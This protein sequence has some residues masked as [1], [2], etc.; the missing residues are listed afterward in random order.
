MFIERQKLQLTE[1]DEELRK[2]ARANRGDPSDEMTKLRLRRTLERSKPL[3]NLDKKRIL[4]NLDR[5][6]AR[7]ERLRSSG[8][9][10]RSKGLELYRILNRRDL[11]GAAQYR[12][13][14]DPDNPF[15]RS[16]LRR[17]ERI[18]DLAKLARKIRKQ[19]PEDPRLDR[20]SRLRTITQLRNDLGRGPSKHA[21]T[22]SPYY[23]RGLRLG[24][25]SSINFQNEPHFR[26]S[27]NDA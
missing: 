22:Y 12:A 1:S 6:D 13:A 27:S 14:T 5:I 10:E 9:L 18:E 11:R 26:H 2:L 16:E 7:R 23:R 15:T 21:V 25:E 17:T 4:R 8:R 3:P 19:N 24:P 20:L